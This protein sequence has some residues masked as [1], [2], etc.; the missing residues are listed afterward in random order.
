LDDRLSPVE[1]FARRREL[2][3]ELSDLGFVDLVI[4]NEAPALLAHRA[5]QGRLL[6]KRDPGLYVEF[7]V[8]TL[9]A[10]EDERHWRDMD[11]RAR[12]QRLREG[13]FG[14]P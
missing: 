2:I 9:G 7:F 5:L 13:R 8:H 6:L 11:H 3:A 4:L 1:R 10:S 14:R 12:V